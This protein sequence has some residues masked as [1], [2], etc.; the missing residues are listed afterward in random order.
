VDAEGADGGVVAAKRGKWKASKGWRRSILRYYI[1]AMIELCDENADEDNVGL[2]LL[3]LYD[4]NADEDNIGLWLHLFVCMV[5]SE[6]FFSHTPMGQLGFW[7]HMQ[8]MSLHWVSMPR[9]RR[10]GNSCSIVR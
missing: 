8:M 6:L 1:H 3:E 7:R 2:W 5:L 4:E 10:F 9:S